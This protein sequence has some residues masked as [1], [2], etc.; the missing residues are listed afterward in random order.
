MTV[1]SLVEIVP[2]HGYEVR[3]VFDAHFAGAH[4]LKTGQLYATLGRLERDALIETVG[5]D[6]G[7]GPERTIYAATDAGR[8]TVVDWLAAPE[9]DAP[10]LQSVVFAKV[11]LALMAQRSAHAVVEVQRRS[12]LA[13]MRQWTAARR[14]A[15]TTE[16][17]IGADFV[18]F[19]LDADLR[20][21][22]AT[23]ARID[24]LAQEVAR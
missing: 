15:P 24:R 2:R 8:R 11:V 5:V 22:E 21:L 10:Y 20:W 7:A 6:R 4:P 19:H 3:K 9:P 14:E 16:S 18:L 17:A 23:A 13:L 1:L 12:H